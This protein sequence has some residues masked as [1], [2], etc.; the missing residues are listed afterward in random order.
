M[1][2][3]TYLNNL[4]ES[5]KIILSGDQLQQLMAFYVC[6]IEQN[7]VM[8]LTAITEFEEVCRKHFLDS[9]SI[10][11]LPGMMESAKTL[12]DVGCGAGFPGL[13]LAIAYPKVQVTLLDSLQKRIGFL[14]SVIDQL[15]LSNCKAVHGRAEDLAREKSHRES[16]DLVV[17]RAVAN[18]STLSEYC[19]P[20]VR[21]DGF[22]VAYKS[23]KIAEEAP[24]AQQAIKI[25]GGRSEEGA[26]F[27][28]TKDS[29]EDY[30]NL[31]VIRKTGRT[32]GKYPRKAGLPAKEPL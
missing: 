25:L 29:P 12:L 17:S 2:Q 31:Y 18:L 32:P 28:L 19:L 3:E 14:N 24:A 21:Q 1:N 10:N 30:R 20:F 8:N 27:Y 26:E 15:G 4:L 9:L 6:L 11:R 16:Y 5:H 13:V 7:K 23:A 22:F